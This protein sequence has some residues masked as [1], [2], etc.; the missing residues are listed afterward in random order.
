LFTNQLHIRLA[1]LDKVLARMSRRFLALTLVVALVLPSVAGAQQPK[2]GIITIPEGSATARRAVLPAPVPLK[3]KDEVFL[4]DGVTTGDRSLVRMLLGGKALI[5]VRER[6]H[7][8]ITEVPGRSTVDLESGKAA[9]AVARDKMAQGE[10][11]NFRT[12]N[13]VAAVRGT[14]I[15]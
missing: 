15:V 12:P 10:V 11:I 6:S 2:A 9:L 4:Q 13:A 7:V 3:F 5:T 1:T 14:V 8:T